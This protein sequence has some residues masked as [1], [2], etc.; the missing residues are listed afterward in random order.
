M[1]AFVVLL[2]LGSVLAL[3]PPALAADVG[4]GVRLGLSPQDVLQ[5]RSLRLVSRD[6]GY[7][8][9]SGERK[10]FVGSYEVL[11]TEDFEFLEEELVSQTIVIRDRL[12]GRDSR[13][14]YFDV[15]EQLWTSL[16]AEAPDGATEVL[17]TGGANNHGLPSD[18]TLA[19]V[20]IDDH[21]P[22]TLLLRTSGSSSF[23]VELIQQ[24]P[25]FDAAARTLRQP[26]SVSLSLPDCSEGF[27]VALRTPRRAD[28]AVGWGDEV[29]TTRERVAVSFKALTL[30]Q[31]IPSP[32]LDSRLLL[33]A[34]LSLRNPNQL[35][36]SVRFPGE[37]P[38][39]HA[40]TGGD[41]F[42]S[43]TLLSEPLEFTLEV[44]LE[45]GLRVLRSATKV[46][47]RF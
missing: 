38:P 41:Q 20:L 34:S 24:H 39:P 33:P 47:K 18:T 6:E 7:E 19:R 10:A 37:R 15:Y 35:R 21:V 8:R 14:F 3:S 11:L 22:T 28:Q 2:A 32:D 30:D 25:H 16:V 42:Q 13:E 5:G 31:E 12:N 43:L 9:Y 27:G 23:V 17:P 1:R 29:N 44:E 46:A 4:R 40:S 36:L 26:T 45:R